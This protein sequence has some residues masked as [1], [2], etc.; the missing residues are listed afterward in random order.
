MRLH[1]KASLYIISVN[2]LVFIINIVILENLM[3]LDLRIRGSVSYHK[4]PS[5]VLVDL[6]C[7]WFGLVYPGWLYSHRYHQ[8]VLRIWNKF[9]P[10]LI[11]CPLG[12]LSNFV[13]II[14]QVTYRRK[15]TLH[16][17]M[18][19]CH[20]NQ[21]ALCSDMFLDLILQS[22]ESGWTGLS[23]SW[24]WWCPL[25]YPGDFQ[26]GFYYCRGKLRVVAFFKAC[27]ERVVDST[28]CWNPWVIF[29]RTSVGMDSTPVES[30]SSSSFFF[31]AQCT[32]SVNKSQFWVLPHGPWNPQNH[33]IFLKL[34][35]AK[36]FNFL[37]MCFIK[38]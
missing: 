37:Q 38:L 25:S 3:G 9:S 12:H 18:L 6:D 17:Y 16:P 20:C 35:S 36:G 33:G 11:I 4:G 32:F 13:V 2:T 31:G 8:T 23:F 29:P 26:L 21:R 15:I 19:T 24:I 30:S 5:A 10:F 22:R 34:L 1:F 7:G 14:S 28:T 27:L